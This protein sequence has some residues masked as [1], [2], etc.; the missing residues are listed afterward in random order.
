MR[1]GLFLS[2]QH[3]DGDD[4]VRRVDEHLE[5]VRFARDHGFA[6]V[7]C[8][9][10]FLPEPF[11]MLQTVPLL[12]RIAAEAGEMTVASGILLITLLNP[13]EVAEN[14]ATLD[15]ITGGRFT[16]G[17]GLGY[18]HEENEAFGL[19]AERVSV[20]REKL[21]VIRRLLEG[22]TVTASGHGYRLDG[23]RLTLRPV[24]R[25]R[26]PIWMAANNDGAVRRAARLADTWLVNPHTTIDQL[27]RQLAL[28]RA[29]RGSEPGEL[30]AIRECLIAPTDEEA[31][32]LARPHLDRKYRAYVDWG[33]SDVMP[34][35][36]TLRQEWET[37][38]RGRFIVGSPATALADA[39]EHRDRL[40]LTQLIV[41][42]QWP[43]LPPE[44]A[45][46]TLDLLAREVAP[47]V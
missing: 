12:G 10:H 33:Q 47:H 31:L 19:P 15:V 21:D 45:L 14:A 17:V 13:V 38:R 28:F 20:F 1:L 41:R 46:R 35:G 11:A 34:A 24:Q 23:Q 37:L 40:G 27:E 30:P 8:G 3:P 16:L 6:T 26:P 39:L 5:Q 25:P 9:Q 32:E 2:A 29:E 18:R 44:H 42:V 7:V 43:G 36:D 22:E 4:L